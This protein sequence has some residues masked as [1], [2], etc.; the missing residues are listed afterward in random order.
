MSIPTNTDVAKL[1]NAAEPLNRPKSRPGFTA[2]VALCALPGFA[3]P[4]HSVSRS[5]TSTS[6]S[7]PS[8]APASSSE[9]SAPT[10]QQ[11]RISSRPSPE[12]T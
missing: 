5:A 4:R 6:S 12:S 9:P 10:W 7:E 3:G 8:A 2:Y 11:A 1:L